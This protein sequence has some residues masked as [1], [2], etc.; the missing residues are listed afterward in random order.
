MN[1]LHEIEELLLHGTTTQP[2][3]VVVGE[4]NVGPAVAPVDL[5]A[6][7]A[8]S[9]PVVLLVEEHGAFTNLS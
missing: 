1:S 2:V 3:A 9:E 7:C 8:T 4:G 5:R 6:T